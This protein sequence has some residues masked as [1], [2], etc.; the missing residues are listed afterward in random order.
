MNA[1]VASARS[2]VLVWMALMLLLGLTLWSAYVHMGWFNVVVNLG[3]SVAKMLLVMIFFMHLRDS[4]ALVR[5]FSGIG[6]LWLLA[7]L[8]LSLSDYLSRIDIP[9]PW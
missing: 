6:F 4:S 3:V 9:P 7:L 2:Y 1:R 8:V 5:I